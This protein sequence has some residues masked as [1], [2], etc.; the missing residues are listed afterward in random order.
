MSN[1][2]DIKRFWLFLKREI[3]R[4]YND[5]G[6]TTLILGL[7]PVILF[8]IVEAFALIIGGSMVEFPLCGIIGFFIA[9]VIG[10]IVLPIRL[11]GPL[12]DKRFGSEWLMIPASR[13]E[14]FLT[15]MLICC[16]VAPLCLTAVTFA[17]DGIMSLC[18]NANY[19][20]VIAKTFNFND[21][22]DFM[23]GVTNGAFDED[24][25]VN[26]HMSIAGITILNWITYIVFFLLGAIIFKKSKF[27]LTLLCIWALGVV[28]SMLSMVA[29][30]A[31]DLEG[32]IELIDVDNNPQKF[33]D[34]VMA[35]VYGVYA[36]YVLVPTF[37]I[38]RR[39]K[40]LKH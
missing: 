15:M 32:T 26:L 29:I 30:A 18:F 23:A 16:V 1:T 37:F 24:I 5:M 17:A 8:T 35:I 34:I 38:W 40:T 27:G 11:Y 28:I 21:F 25:P 33:V 22:T 3:V 14:K 4:A 6:V 13:L 19:G 7:A 36:I 31:F 12:T 2:F 9:L 10:C 39:V 20:G